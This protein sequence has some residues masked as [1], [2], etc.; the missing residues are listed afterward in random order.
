M[1]NLPKQPRP[2]DP[3]ALR[4][5][6]TDEIL[7]GDAQHGW[8]ATPQP[9]GPTFSAAHILSQPLAVPHVRTHLAMLSY[10]RRNRDRH[11]IIGQLGRLI[12]AGPGTATA[13]IPAR[14][15]RRRRR[16]RRRAHA[17]PRRPRRCARPQLRPKR[18]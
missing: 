12:V 11:E 16:Q 1:P 2:L 14:Q 18:P 4:A 9:S 5:A 10:G 6:W 15:H 3:Q 7:P 17:R 8:P 13:P